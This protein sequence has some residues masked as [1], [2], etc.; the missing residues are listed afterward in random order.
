V[1][2]RKLLMRICRIVLHEF[3]IEIGEVLLDKVLISSQL[4]SLNK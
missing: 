3:Q 2:I 1:L 4:L